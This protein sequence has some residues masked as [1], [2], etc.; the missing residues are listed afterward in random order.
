MMKFGKD[1]DLNLASRQYRTTRI[2]ETSP[3]VAKSFDE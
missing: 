2:W 1:Y 3:N